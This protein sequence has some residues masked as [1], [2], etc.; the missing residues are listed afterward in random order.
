[1]LQNGFCTK[2]QLQ[3]WLEGPEKW[4]MRKKQEVLLESGMGRAMPYHPYLSDMSVARITKTQRQ[5]LGFNLK[6][7]R[8]KQPPTRETFYLYQIFRP[9][10]RYCVSTS[11]CP[12]SSIFLS[13]PG[14]LSPVSITL[15]LGLKVCDPKHWNWDHLCVSPVSI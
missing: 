12:F 1:M 3:T 14:H 6:I 8:A 15:V 9:K 10:G 2:A 13:L 5:I 11:S 7:R 4:T